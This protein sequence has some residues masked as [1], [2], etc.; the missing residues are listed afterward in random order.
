M[1]F[2]TPLGDVLTVREAW[3]LIR[4]ACSQPC[5]PACPGRALGPKCAQCHGS[6]LWRPHGSRERLLE[7]LPELL[8]TLL[9]IAGGYEVMRDLAAAEAEYAARDTEAVRERLV[10]LAAV[11]PPPSAAELALRAELAAEAAAAEAAAAESSQ[12]S[13]AA[14]AAAEAEAEAEAAAELADDVKVGVTTP[15]LPASQRGARVWTAA[16]SGATTAPEGAKGS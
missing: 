10:Q 5:P 8:R 4:G 9:V 3:D 15:E 2:P 11:A 6:Q 16:P 1:P 13:R 14:E 7:Q 12:A